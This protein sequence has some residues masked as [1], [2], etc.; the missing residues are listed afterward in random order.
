MATKIFKPSKTFNPYSDSVKN[1][2]V[3][4]WDQEKTLTDFD[5]YI[6]NDIY[7]DADIKD[8]VDLNCLKLDFIINKKLIYHCISKN[9]SL[10]DFIDKIDNSRILDIIVKN[11]IFSKEFIEDH[12]SDY[13]HKYMFDLIINHCK[14]SNFFK[15]I[16]VHLTRKNEDMLNKF[17]N[18]CLAHGSKFVVS[19]IDF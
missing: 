8:I 19:A 5:A 17:I 9:I 7:T 13:S 3:K 6:I 10:S 14:N 18:Q 16:V 4:F 2:L 1:I 11:G 15:E 12:Y